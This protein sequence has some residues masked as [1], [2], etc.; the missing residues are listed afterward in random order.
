MLIH[1]AEIRCTLA[2][3]PRPLFAFVGATLLRCTYLRLAHHRTELGQYFEES[4]ENVRHG[5]IIGAIIFLCSKE[6]LAR[7][8]NDVIH[9]H[10]FLDTGRSQAIR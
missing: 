1:I 8:P 5:I 6:Q 7:E 4:L 2:F 3:G 9:K 10:G